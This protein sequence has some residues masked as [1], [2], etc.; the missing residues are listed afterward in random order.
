MANAVVGKV[1]QVYV[2]RGGMYLEMKSITSK[3]KPT[4]KDNYY[5]LEHSHENYNSVFAAVLTA[6]VNQH[7]LL[8]RPMD[9]K[10]VTDYE[11]VEYVQVY[12]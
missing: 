4:T 10:K 1:K 2:D 5:Y 7:Q 11:I 12:F 3:T 8:V 9:N 6:G